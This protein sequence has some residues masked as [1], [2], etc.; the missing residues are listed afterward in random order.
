VLFH[1][2]NNAIPERSMQGTKEREELGE[3]IRR[4][5]RAAG[6]RQQDLAEAAGVGISLVTQL[7]QGRTKDPRLTTLRA[8]ANALGVDM[9]ELTG[10]RPRSA[11]KQ[12]S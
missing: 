2:Q 6:M 4:L 8:L 12:E 1:Y 11:D 7:E 9:N 3:V 5:R 10:H